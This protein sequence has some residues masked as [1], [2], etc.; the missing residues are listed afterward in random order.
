MPPRPL[1]ELRDLVRYRKAKIQERTREV[2][3]V[4]KTLQ[5]AGIKLSSVA[6]EVLGVSARNMLDALISDTNDP[7]V[8]A[9]L[10]RGTLHKKIPALREALAGRFTGHHALPRGRCYRLAVSNSAVRFG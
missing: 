9:E 7:E 3:R 10:A 6:S 2:Q 1:R 5:D 8:L 4:E